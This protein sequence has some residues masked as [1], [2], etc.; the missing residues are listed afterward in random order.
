MLATPSPTTCS[1]GQGGCGHG[2]FALKWD[3]LHAYLHNIKPPDNSS[4]PT[5][6]DM[7]TPEPQGGEELSLLVH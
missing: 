3:K 4:A 2:A 1:G 6:E 7:D 5:M